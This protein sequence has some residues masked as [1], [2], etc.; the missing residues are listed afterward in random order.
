MKRILDI[1]KYDLLAFVP[2]SGIPF[3]AHSFIKLLLYAGFIL[4]C[5]QL[6]YFSGSTRPLFPKVEKTI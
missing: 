4:F 5:L 6:F 2:G 1:F 3:N